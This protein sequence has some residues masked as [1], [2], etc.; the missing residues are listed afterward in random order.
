MSTDKAEGNVFLPT[1]GWQEAHHL[2]WVDVMRDDN[3]LCL[4]FFNESSHMVKTILELN[5]LGGFALSTSLSFI[6]KALFLVLLGFRA[7]L[8]E[9]FKEFGS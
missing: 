4:V 3:E 9:Q 2:D 7:V 6:F 5:W 8:G 1:K